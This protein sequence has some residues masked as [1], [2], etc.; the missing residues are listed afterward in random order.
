M[1]ITIFTIGSRGDVQPYVSLGCRLQEAGHTVSI[2][3]YGFYRQ[4]IEAYGLRIRPFPGNPQELMS[5]SI[6]R[7]WVASQ[8]NP[9]RFIRAFIALT[10]SQLEPMFTS[11]SICED[12]DLIVYSD[13]GV[14]GYHVAEYLGIPSISTHLQ[15]FGLTRE[16]PAVG[17][18]PWLR[19]GGTYNR[20]SH[21]LTGQVMWQPFRASVNEW[22]R[23]QLSLP[24]VPFW[25]PYRRL[26]RQQQPVLSAFSATVVPKPADW[27]S[28][29]RI[30][31]Y[32]FLPPP[33]GWTPPQT[34]LDFLAAGPAPVYIGFG[35]MFDGDPIALTE[36]VL[37]AVQRAGVRVVLSSG[38][39]SLVA[40]NLPD[41][42]YMVSSVPHEWLFPQMAA[43]AHHGGAGTT[44]A[45]L[46]AGVPS[47][48]IPY[49]ADQHFW[50]NRIY[51]LGVGPRPV[52]RRRLTVDRLTAVLHQVTQNVQIRK[53]AANVGR[54]I[55]AEDGPGVAL[56]LIEA[57]FERGA[58]ELPKRKW[59]PYPRSPRIRRI[60]RFR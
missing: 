3:T 43:V 49:F 34:L 8:Q 17:S 42:V 50:G 57:Y 55:R 14:V 51:G 44:A 12:T 37:S 23:E 48:V 31:G 5:S 21:L 59:R 11:A 58:V 32:W 20:I 25:G 33:P 60:L 27:T 2:A 16:F 54:K 38:W 7:E 29:H 1:N 28:R 6:A 40:G 13:L 39:G 56:S 22:R 19:L 35:S 4:F 46:R 53:R 36:L 15:P 18:P 10:K 47:A 30:T 9:V 41:D 45:G 26:R 52:A 24:P